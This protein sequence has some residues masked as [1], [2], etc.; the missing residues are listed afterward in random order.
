MAKKNQA[1]E[2]R[3]V[4]SILQESVRVKQKLLKTDLGLVARAA[5][6]IATSLQHGGRT[7][8]FGNGGSAGDAQHLSGELQGRFLKERRALAGLALT[9]DTSTITAVAND[10]SYAEVFARQIEGLGQPGDVAIGISTSGGSKNVIKAL[11]KAR[12]LGMVTIALTGSGG[13]L[14]QKKRLADICICVPSKCTP[15]IQESHITIGH[16][17]MELVETACA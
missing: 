14:I 15:R 9:T 12:K 7:Y 11:Q 16:A 6:L 2:T 4:K 1:S 5:A 8:F 13:G 10:Y 17:I 3:R